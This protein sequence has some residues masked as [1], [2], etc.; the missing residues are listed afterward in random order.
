MVL[1]EAA[2]ADVLPALALE[3][4]RGGVEENELEIGEEVAA[5]GE[6][7]LLDPVF[8]APRCERRLV[9]LLIFGQ[10]F[11][12]PSHGAVE[13][14]EL[15]FVASFDRVVRLPLVGGAVAAGGEEAMEHG[16]E[17]GALDVELIAASLEKL[18]DHPLTPGL[19]PEPLENE[20]RP[21]AACGDDRDLSLG[22]RR[23]EPDRL[24]ETRA[25]DQ[26]GVELP[27]LLELIEPPQR[28]DDALPW[29]S[30]LPAVLDDLEVGPCAGRLGAEK[31]D[32][33]VVET[34]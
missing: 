12:K 14:V 13:V 5:V 11:T 25:R 8:D 9:L 19:A 20:G 24:G 7:V 6:E 32:A 4:D 23:E 26:E 22:E 16:E 31:H 28:G 27:G 30:I 29:S 34:P 18:R 33:S 2:P 17:D 21:D 1:A 15:E 10:L 3:V